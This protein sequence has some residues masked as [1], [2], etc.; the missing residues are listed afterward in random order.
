M[1]VQIFCPLLKQVMGSHYWVVRKFYIF[2]CASMFFVRDVFS[3][4]VTEFY[5]LNRIF[6]A[7]KVLVCLLKLLS[8][9]YQF[10]L[11]MHALCVL[12]SLPN[13]TEDF[14][15]LPWRSFMIL[16]FT[17]MLIIHFRLHLYEIWHTVKVAFLSICIFNASPTFVKS[18]CPHIVFHWHPCRTTIALTRVCLLLDSLCFCSMY[19]YFYTSTTTTLSCWLWLCSNLTKLG[20]VGM[21]NMCF[22]FRMFF[23]Y[24]NL[25]YDSKSCRSTLLISS[26]LNC[27]ESIA[28]LGE[29]LYLSNIES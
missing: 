9:V 19:V 20:R 14:L 16:S 12:R 25:L 24:C 18:M 22:S 29:N 26:H 28:Q 10:T 8:P 17:C 5:F 4:S 3:L 11:I 7:A 15:L 21:P 2:T 23:G 1:S 27:C 13:S 6:P